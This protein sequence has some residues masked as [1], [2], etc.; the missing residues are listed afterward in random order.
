MTITYDKFVSDYNEY[1]QSNV[2][3]VRVSTMDIG[4][5]FWNL[6]D[7]DDFEIDED[8]GAIELFF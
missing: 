7:T 1:Y 5:I 2:R 6:Y 8:N 3:V 4:E